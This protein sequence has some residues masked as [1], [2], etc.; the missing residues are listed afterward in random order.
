LGG[1]FPK[2]LPEQLGEARFIYFEPD[3]TPRAV[4]PPRHDF[5]WSMRS[6]FGGQRSALLAL[7]AAR[8]RAQIGALA[9]RWGRLGTVGV[10]ILLGAVLGFLGSIFLP[11][12][13]QR[14]V[15]NGVVE[16]QH[17]SYNGAIG[18]WRAL[19]NTLLFVTTMSLLFGSS[20][21]GRR[22]KTA[23][24]LV[25]VLATTALAAMWVAD[26]HAEA[27]RNEKQEF[28]GSMMSN[29]PPVTAVYS[30]EPA[31]GSYLNLALAAV[32]LG[33]AV[34][35]ARDAWRR[36]GVTTDATSPLRVEDLLYRGEDE[37]RELA[38][39]IGAAGVDIDWRRIA[40]FFA[41]ILA[42]GL[43]AMLADA[44]PGERGDHGGPDEPGRAEHSDQRFHTAAPPAPVMAPA[45]VAAPASAPA[46]APVAAPVPA[47]SPR[48]ASTARRH[49]S[50]L[51]V[52]MFT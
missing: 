49:A 42:M 14:H 26:E 5:N 8:G 38:S 27:F 33:A 36:T 34:V 41:A 1:V 15:V 13:T 2:P 45:P 48:L 50:R 3:W 7:L 24:V 52:C 6:L 28:R 12:Y 35:L 18:G 4:A 30:R 16:Y 21:T 37:G 25:L 20:A 40:G 29:A 51:R 47:R 11:A 44:A 39:V 23:A 43:P 46:V 32:V 19:T 17:T 31:A 10:A 22:L 9:G